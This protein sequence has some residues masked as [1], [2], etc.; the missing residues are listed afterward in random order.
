ML[1]S[2]LGPSDVKRTR[3]RNASASRPGATGFRV[4]V[5]AAA[6]VAVSEVGWGRLPAPECAVALRDPISVSLLR[7]PASRTGG[8]ESVARLSPTWCPQAER[9][10]AGMRHMRGGEGGDQLF[11]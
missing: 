1:D 6:A 10:H 2:N 11:I 4:V 5:A 7:A 9:T 3:H 8:K